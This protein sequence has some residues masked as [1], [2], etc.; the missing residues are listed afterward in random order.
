MKRILVTGGAGFL[1]SHLCKALV[2]D[3]ENHVIALDDLS[4]GRM[5]NIEPLMGRKN[6]TW[7]KGDVREPLDLQVDEIYNAAC[8]ASPP[9]YQSRPI[10]TLETCVLGVGNL[11][12]L[13][14]RSGARVLQFSTSEVY[15]EP[16][17]HPQT[18]SYRGNVSTIGVR[19][20]YDEGKRCAEALIAA[21]RREHGTDARIVR[22][23]NTYGPNMDENDGRVV[24]NF[25]MQALRGEDITVYGTGAQTRC[26]CYVSDM[27]RGLIAAM[28]A[29]ALPDPVNLGNPNE[30]TVAAIAERVLLLTGSRSRIA[31]RSLPDDDPT[32]RRPDIARAARVLGWWPEIPL[33]EGLAL[34]IAYFRTRV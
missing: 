1:G 10:K 5:A 28:A 29:P 32:R 7:I 15:G 16:L 19:S 26:F 6:F 25:I 14:N 30:V 12:A 23:F 31:Y 13:A 33:D 3:L 4:T 21:H 2:N 34:S 18:E 22:I 24:S 17:V 8:P 9:A 11:L 27:V 20:C